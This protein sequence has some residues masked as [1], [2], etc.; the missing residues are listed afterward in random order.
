MTDGA[1]G[2]RRVA[3]SI[4][5][6][7]LVA[8]VAVLA[9]GIGGTTIV[10]RQVLLERVD[11][12]IDGSLRQQAEELRLLAT[13]GVDPLTGQGFG[14]DVARLLI[15]FLEG[16]VPGPGEV[17]IT[18]LGGAPFRRTAQRVPYRVDTDPSLTARWGSTTETMRGAVDT[19]GGRFD[20]LA[21]PVTG[22]EDSAVFLV[23]VFHDVV[24]AEVDQTVRVTAWVALASLLVGLAVTIGFARRLLTPIEELTDAA[25]EITDS[26]LSRRL[27]VRGRDEVAQLATTFNAMLDRLQDA[28]RLQRQF[29]DDAG[30]ELRTP[31]TVVRGHVELLEGEAD[32]AER[33][34]TTELVLDELDRMHRIVE[35]LLTLAQAEQPDFIRLAPFDLDELTT[36]VRDKAEAISPAHH[37]QLD[38][39]G[40]ARV[41][42]DAQRLTQALVQ[43]C[44]NAAKYAPAGTTI[45]IGSRIDGGRV[46]LWVR[47]D[48]PGIACEDHERIFERFARGTDGPRRSEGAGL[49]LSIVRAIARSHHGD[50]SVASLPG[51][52]TAFTLCFPAPSDADTVDDTDDGDHRHELTE[53]LPVAPDEPVPVPDPRP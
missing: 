18:Y 39:V 32:P 11:E 3:S 43:L 38:D 10:T 6:R 52:G 36:S 33:R 31:I 30:H 35:D 34:R 50:V 2:L 25:R 37:W 23:G 12:R 22:S 42:G 44:D 29:I 19:P 21:V 15:V 26:D 4:R 45:G 49:G 27:E 40:V 46:R 8:M 24:A 28:F 16:S 1:M 51:Q 53:A 5:T 41:H 47:D 17:S 20:Y 9:V 48:G 13:E 14:T 7:L